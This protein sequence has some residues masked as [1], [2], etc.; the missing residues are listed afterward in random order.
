MEKC[1]QPYEHFKIDLNDQIL[2]YS[3]IPNISN[4]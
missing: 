3:E 1:S 4:D 2:G